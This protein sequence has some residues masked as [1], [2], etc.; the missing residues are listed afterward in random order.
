MG[1]NHDLLADKAGRAI[2]SKIVARFDNW[3]QVFS[4]NLSKAGDFSWPR[5]DYVCFDYDLDQSIAFEF[6]P[7]N[8]AKREYLTGL[9]QTL[10]YLEKHHYSGIILPTIVEGYYIAQHLTNILSLDVFSRHYIAVIGYDEKTL[11][12][13]PLNSIQLFKPIEHERTGEIV[14]EHINQTYWCWWRDISHYEIFTLLNLLDKFAN[15]LGDIYTHYAWP[16]FWQLMISRKTRTWEGIG[17]IKTDN[18]TNYKSEKQNYKIPLFQLG[19]IEP[20][21]GRLTAKGYKLISIGKIFGIESSLYMDYLTKLVL[22]EGKHLTLI[23]D[24]ENYKT[25]A[26]AISLSNSTQFRKDFET[27]LDENNS[28]GQRKEGRTTTGNKES[29]IRDE[30]KLWNKL[31]LL[32]TRGSRYFKVGRGIEFNWARITEILTKEFSF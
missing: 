20:S 17:R 16:E 3:G 6:K 9:G 7:P 25:K 24:L 4:D 32:K 30:L 31:G 28:I 11:E 21:E 15:Q 2:I 1:A 19:L 8:H 13:D 18:N 29:Y 5:P 26:K 27:Y 23:Q 22:I 10:S 14:S 12:S